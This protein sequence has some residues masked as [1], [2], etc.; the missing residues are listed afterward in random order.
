MTIP[1][2]GKRNIFLD[3]FSKSLFF[4]NLSIGIIVK[5]EISF[6]MISIAKKYGPPI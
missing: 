2:I 6:I 4:G 1:I 5:N 3:I